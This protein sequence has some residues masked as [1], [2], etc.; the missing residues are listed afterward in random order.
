MRRTSGNEE[1]DGY[2]LARTVENLGMVPERASRDRARADRDDYFRMGHGRV[3][4]LER[5][6]HV[7]GN[8]TGDQESVR[9]PRRRHELNAEASQVENNRIKNVNVSFASIAAAGADLSEFERTSEN[10]VEIGGQRMGGFESLIFLQQ[11]I[12]PVAC[13]KSI[14]AAEAGRLLW[15]GI[16]ALRTKEASPQVNLHRAFDRYRVRWAGVSAGVTSGG[17]SRPVDSRQ[18]A[19]ALRQVRLRLRKRQ[20]TL[21][22]AQSSDQQIRHHSSSQIVT[23]VRKVEAFVAE[24][25]I[26]D[27]LIAHRA[28]KTHPI[29]K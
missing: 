5:E 7:A 20:R 12:V 27:L 24:R 26:R 6:V 22:L 18:A 10:A 17:A 23:A 14:F 2:N 13:R 28:G 8:G 4:L 29:A 15:T 11:Q 1:I 21:A 9:M 19:E 25:E 16:S 3:G